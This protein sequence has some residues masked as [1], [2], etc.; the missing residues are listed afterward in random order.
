MSKKKISC[1]EVMDYI[2]DHAGES[3]DSPKCREI[4]EHLNECENC[5]H[6]FESVDKTISFYKIYNVQIPDEAHKRLLSYLGLN[7]E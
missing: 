5:K 2:C 6:F 1:K 4:K 3:F 7:D